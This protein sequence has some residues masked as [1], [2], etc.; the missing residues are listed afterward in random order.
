MPQVPE[1]K[2]SE[3]KAATSCAQYI[4]SMGF[5]MTQSGDDFLCSCPLDGHQDKNPSF[6][7]TGPLYNCLSRCGGGNVFQLVQKMEQCDFLAAVEKLAVLGGVAFNSKTYRGHGRPKPIT[8]ECPLDANGSDDELAKQVIDFYQSQ[9]LQRG[10]AGW[11]YLEKR[12]LA[13]RDL[14][15]RFRLGFAK[16]GELGKKLPSKQVVAGK[17]LRVQLEKIGFFK[18][19]SGHEYF[20]GSLTVPI[21]HGDTLMDCY[22]RKTCQRL[23]AGTPHHLYLPKDARP[24]ESRGVWNTE[25]IQQSDNKTLILCESLIDALSVYKNGYH[26]VTCAYGVNNFTAAMIAAYKAA[27]IEEILIA[28]DND[29]SGNISAAALAEKLISEGLTVSRLQVPAALNDVNA[30]LVDAG[31]DSQQAM[32][33]LVANARWIGGKSKMFVVVDD[34]DSDTEKPQTQPKTPTKPALSFTEKNKNNDLFVDIG[35]RSWRVRSFAK[36]TV[37]GVLKIQLRVEVTKGDDDCDYFLDTLDLCSHKMRQQFAKTASAELGLKADVFAGDLKKLLRELEDKQD[38]MINAATEKSSSEVLPEMTTAEKDEALAALKD[39]DLIAHI[40]GDLEKAGLIGEEISRLVCYLAATSRLLPDPLGIVIQSSSSAGKSSVMN[41]ILKMM[42]DEAQKTFVSMSKQSLL[43]LDENALA[44]KIL[45]VAELAGAKD[46]CYN[47]KMLLSEK[48]L[49][50]ASV[51]QDPTTGDMHTKEYRVNGPAALILTTTEEDDDI[52]NELLNRCLILSVTETA[53]QTEAILQRQRYADTIAGA[54]CSD[55]RAA[56]QKK[57]H[58]MQRLLRPLRVVNNY[59]PQLTFVATETRHRRDHQK[60][61]N[62][63]KSIALL[64]QHQREIK[65]HPTGFEYIEVTVDDIAVANHVAAVV[66]GRSL[67]QLTPKAKALLHIIDGFVADRAERDGIARDAV[68]FTRKELRQVCRWN[69]ATLHRHL[70]K[71]QQLDI[72]SADR[73]SSVQALSYVLHYT[74][75]DRKRDT[76]VLNLIDPAHLVDPSVYD[77]VD[78]RFREVDLASISHGS[79]ADL[80]SISPSENDEIPIKHSPESESDAFTQ[81]MHIRENLNLHRSFNASYIKTV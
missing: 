58:N 37:P 18:S 38:A 14:V 42:P 10:N 12:G 70:Y 11:A 9:L 27:Q 79:H 64:H 60:Y 69:D 8:A 32:F 28:Y 20:A 40:G 17:A 43:Y 75:A 67:D 23:R 1:S 65:K 52:D 73:G 63:I 81:K 48:Y 47:V 49:S 7:M 51:S 80:T 25:G 77:A 55:E 74:H 50:M 41:A 78:L 53:A 36:N 24:H 68:C 5:P 22:G 35:S 46:I 34:L 2:L 54:A 39:P 61:L 33:D 19:G 45:G 72:I 15:S 62:L 76:V 30:Y 26:A 16:R 21:F 57:H 3:I 31:K 56:I 66:L 44:H 59:A 71:I 29:D 4:E 6:R 13:D